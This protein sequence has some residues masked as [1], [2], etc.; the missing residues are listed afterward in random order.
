[1]LSDTD[2]KKYLGKGIHIEPFEERY[3]SPIGYDFRVGEWAFSLRKRK[4]YDLKTRDRI[5]VEPGDTMVVRTLEWMSLSNEFGATIHSMVSLLTEGGISHISTT[6]DP[7]HNGHLLIQFH[8]QSIEPVILTY[9]RPFCTVCF[10]HMDSPSTLRTPHEES[11][12]RLERKLIESAHKLPFYRRANFRKG[13]AG[14]S[15][16]VV[17]GIAI[18]QF[19]SGVD[20]TTIGATASVLGLICYIVFNFL[21]ET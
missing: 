7:T 10:Y 11:R 6:V 9:K 14:I 18:W 20:P 8:N 15:I 16:T 12:H 21:R 17:G 3:L 19:A 4:E 2:I 5:V 1:M 13:F